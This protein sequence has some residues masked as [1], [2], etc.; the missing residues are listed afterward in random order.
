MVAVGELMTVKD[1]S[2]VQ[3]DDKLRCAD[4][5]TERP[6]AFSLKCALSAGSNVHVLHDLRLEHDG[7]A[8]QLDRV[9]HRLL[10]LPFPFGA[11]NG[12]AHVQVSCAGRGRHSSYHWNV[13]RGA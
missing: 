12:A 6:M 9:L 1:V 11:A 4:A 5:E 13:Y 8:A 2:P 3:R 10:R 7:D